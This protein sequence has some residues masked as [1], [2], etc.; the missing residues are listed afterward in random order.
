[1]FIMPHINILKFEIKEKNG[2]EDEELLCLKK[3]LDEAEKLQM[4]QKNTY[5]KCIKKDSNELIE[6][7]L[8]KYT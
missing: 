2:V 1:M 8:E 3:K 4:M 7:I 5:D 6:V